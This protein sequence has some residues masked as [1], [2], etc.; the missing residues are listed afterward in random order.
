M[1][2]PRHPVRGA[3]LGKAKFPVRGDL[4]VGTG[5]SVDRAGS[6]VTVPGSDGRAHLRRI[7]DA[8]HSARAGS[9][10]LGSPDNWSGI[11]GD[12]RT[13]F[14]ATA[15]GIQWWDVRDPWYPVRGDTTKLAHANSEGMALQGDV[16]AVLT[17]LQSDPTGGNTVRLFEVSAGTVRASTTIEGVI[18]SRPELSDDARLLATTGSSDGTVRLWDISDPRHPRTGATLRTLEDTWGFAFDERNELMADWSTDGGMQLWDIHDPSQ[19]DLKATIPSSEDD[20][21]SMV[22]FLP[23]GSAFAAAGRTGVTFRSAD[24]AGLAAHICSYTGPSMPKAQWRRYAPGIPYRDPC[25]T[26]E[27]PS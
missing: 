3:S 19:P 2:D 16:M 7:T 26:S 12:G 20:R 9:F 6:L 14:V 24:Y 15:E 4:I 27:R 1:R 10:R 25:P 18:G 8:R 13:A 5:I 22:E 17:P 11:M 23:S 21:V